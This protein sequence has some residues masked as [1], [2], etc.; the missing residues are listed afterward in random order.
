MYFNIQMDYFSKAVLL[1][2][3]IGRCVVNRRLI[4]GFMERIV[5]I[6]L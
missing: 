2:G 5:E 1:M 4:N 3:S 6:D